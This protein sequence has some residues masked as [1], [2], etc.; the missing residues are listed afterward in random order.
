MELGKETVAACKDEPPLLNISGFTTRQH[1]NISD[2]YK[3]MQKFIGPLTAILRGLQSGRYG[4]GLSSLQKTIAIDRLRRIIG[5]LHR[6]ATWNKYLSILQRVQKVLEIWFPQSQTNNPLQ[7]CITNLPQ[8][9]ASRMTSFTYNNSLGQFPSPDGQ[10]TIPKYADASLFNSQHRMP[11]SLFGAR[12]PRHPS[13]KLTWTHVLPISCLQQENPRGYVREVPTCSVLSSILEGILLPDCDAQISHHDEKCIATAT[14]QICQICFSGLLTDA[15]FHGHCC[16]IS[17]ATH[18]ERQDGDSS[19][20]GGPITFHKG[21]LNLVTPPSS[22]PSMALATEATLPTLCKHKSRSYSHHKCKWCM[23]KR[24]R[25]V[26]SCP[27]PADVQSSRC[28]QEWDEESSPKH[29][30]R[31]KRSCSDVQDGLEYPAA[32]I[33]ETKVQKRGR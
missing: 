20:A 31:R 26:Q 19:T 13:T 33:R 14:S 24:D 7:A 22:P 28:I 30:T 32:Y 16:S 29:Q 6:P 12:S 25:K 23:I 2:D 18:P 11:T 4:K 27:F 15:L 21:F 10:W 17:L 5:V 8:K 3:Y 1:S 9:G